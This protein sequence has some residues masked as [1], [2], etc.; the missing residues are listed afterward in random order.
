MTPV[1][2]I[3]V[4]SQG[5]GNFSF[6]NV[7]GDNLNGIILTSAEHFMKVLELEVNEKVLSHTLNMLSLWTSKLTADVPQKI[8]E[9]FKV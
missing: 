2:I 7:S 9:A 5:A 1:K 8:V 4:S 3:I 6:N